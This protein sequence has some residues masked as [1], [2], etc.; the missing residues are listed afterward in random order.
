MVGDK[1]RGT[2][3][4]VTNARSAMFWPFRWAI[5]NVWQ[6]R[7]NIRCEWLGVWDLYGTSCL[8]THTYIEEENDKSRDNVGST[9]FF[10][11]LIFF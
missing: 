3:R 10:L 8:Q 11:I 9:T 6:T 1:K 2:N 5:R 7:D 4:S